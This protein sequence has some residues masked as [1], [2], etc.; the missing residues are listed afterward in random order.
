MAGFTDLH[1]HLLPGVDDGPRSDEDSFAL[2]RQLVAD[3][4]RRCVVTPHV[5]AWNPGRL[6]TKSDIE[7]QVSAL[8]VKLAAE[9]IPLDL[10]AGAEHFLTPET[11]ED[12]KSGTA[13]LLGPGPYILV[14]FPFDTRPLYATDLLYQLSLLGLSPVLAHPAR[15]SW[16][17]SNPDEI[18]PLIEAGTHLQATAG[19][20]AGQYGPRVQRTSEYLLRQGWYS[21]AG[22]DIHRAGQPRSLQTM[23]GQV[24]EIAGE[25]AR[26][27]LFFQNPSRVLDGTPLMA[28]PPA[29]PEQRAKKRF[30]LFG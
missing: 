23:A 17:Q 6:R 13:A 30:G 14:E 21:L 24:L 27:I 11:V 16:V 3:G 12:A 9:D 7:E 26:D 25:A 22:T 4:V 1:L 20:L 8:S 28:V 18:Q 10:F 5:N 15:Y 19:S 29:S 2:A